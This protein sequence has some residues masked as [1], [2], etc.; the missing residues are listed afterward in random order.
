MANDTGKFLRNSGRR[1]RLILKIQRKKFVWRSSLRGNENKSG[2]DFENRNLKIF[3][4]LGRIS[5]LSGIFYWTNWWTVCD[6][7]P[8]KYEVSE[9]WKSTK[10]SV[11]SRR[12]IIE[13]NKA[14]WSKERAGREGKQG[15]KFILW[16]WRKGPPYG[17]AYF[18]RLLR[19]S[20][21]R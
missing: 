3:L 2:L 7:S 12:K 21:L 15:W 19:V 1:W 5:N 6:R 8:W 20:I 13:M 17:E 11:N 18:I 14:E 9:K 16:K 10:K 4:I